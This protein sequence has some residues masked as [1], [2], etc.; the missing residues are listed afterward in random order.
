MALLGL[1]V[2]NLVFGLQHATTPTPFSQMPF[3]TVWNAPTAQC[4]SHYG[5]D[6]DLS[7]FSIVQNQDQS[8][9]GGNI[10]IF[11]EDKLGLYPRYSQGEAV[12]G[13]VPQNASLDKHLRA[14]AENICTDIP[15]RD[16]QGLAVVDWESWRPVWERNWESKQVYWEGSRA[17][18][19]AKHPDWSPA[20]IEVVARQEFERAGREFM[21]A[22]VKLGQ[23]DRPLGLWGYY[24]FPSCYNYYSNKSVNYT[25]ECPPIEIK[26]NDELFWLWNVSSALYPEIYLSL[27]MRGLG[28][29]VLL[30]THHRVLE[31]M[32]VAA[33]V[34]PSTP[35]V[36]P[37]ARIVYT[38]TLDLLS[39]ASGH[40]C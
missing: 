10:T 16:F 3:L 36:L 22:T 21:E 12:H 17:L 23:E 29:E 1:N 4:H 14:A 38:Y 31:A 24:G 28:N 25:G 37:Y 5:V 32:R 30:Y 26:R 9:M 8:F 11:Y 7:V 2:V 13:G 33:Q 19:R 35:P 15:D 27:E 40:R 20:Q 39:Q 34:T 18:V 6:L